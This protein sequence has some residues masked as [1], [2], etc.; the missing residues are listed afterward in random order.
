[1]RV[2]PWFEDVPRLAGAAVRRFEN[3]LILL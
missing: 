3:A 2:L 1:M